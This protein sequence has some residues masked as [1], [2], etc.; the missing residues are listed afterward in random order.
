MLHQ[1]NCPDARCIGQFG[2]YIAQLEKG[3]IM[4]S[5]PVC[6]VV[7]LS[8]LYLVKYLTFYSIDI[9]KIVL[10]LTGYSLVILAGRVL[11]K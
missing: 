3:E 4:Y 8:L 1:S 10:Y 2:L 11:I 5:R 9:L 6:F 7:F